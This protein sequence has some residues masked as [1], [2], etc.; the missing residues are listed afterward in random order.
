MKNHLGGFI[1]YILDVGSFVG[2]N[3]AVGLAVTAAANQ[4]THPT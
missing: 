2:L 3:K 1:V 4:I